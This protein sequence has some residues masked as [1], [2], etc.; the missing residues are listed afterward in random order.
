MKKFKGESVE[1]VKVA[2]IPRSENYKKDEAGNILLDFFRGLGWNGEDTVKPTK[3]RTTTE[4][5]DQLYDAIRVAYGSPNPIG[6]GMLMCNNGPGTDDEVPTGK[7]I[8][9]KG[10]T[11]ADSLPI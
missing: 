3:I 4:V 5:F 2:V 10:W 1:D 7:V 6:I 9:L 8:L 11:I